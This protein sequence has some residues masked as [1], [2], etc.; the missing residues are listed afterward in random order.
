MHSFN[1]GPALQVATTDVSDRSAIALDRAAIVAA[2]M[3]PARAPAAAA[4]VAPAPRGT[5]EVANSFYAANPGAATSFQVPFGSADKALLYL[6][7]IYTNSVCR[8]V[9]GSL[10]VLCVAAEA[11][12]AGSDWT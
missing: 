12:G 1:S 7:G 6:S 2:S 3:A 4:A 9:R 8:A 10:H 5:Y 11:H